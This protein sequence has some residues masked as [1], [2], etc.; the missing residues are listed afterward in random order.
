VLKE[1]SDIIQGPECGADDLITQP[2]DVPRLIARIK[3]TLAR[4]PKRREP[5]FERPTPIGF[6]GSQ[7]T[8]TSSQEQILTFLVT[9]FEDFVHG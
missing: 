9:T 5:G 6:M 1:L 4:V 3:S 8:L 7:F 2:Y